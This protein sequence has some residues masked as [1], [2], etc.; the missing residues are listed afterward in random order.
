MA[1][2]KEN[3]KASGREKKRARFR[4]APSTIA[5]RKQVRPSIY[6]L[7]W[8]IF[9]ALSLLIVLLCV[10]TQQSL[11]RQTY[12]TEAT[13]WIAE[14]GR[15]LRE[16]VWQRPPEEFGDN[17]SGYLRYL[18]SEYDVELVILSEE[19]KVLFPQE[20]K[21]D[22]EYPMI[23]EYFDYS[24]ELK[25]MLEKMAKTGETESVYS[26]D[27]EYVYGAEMQ[28]FGEYKTY[29]YIA[30]SAD[31]FI[32]AISKMAVRMT[33]IAVFVIVLAFAVSSA[34]S[35]WVTRPI[36]E[37]TEKAKLLAK[38]N[39]DVD[40]YGVDYAEDMVEL[41][42][43]LNF[44]RDE[45]SKTDRMQKE[46]IA[47]VS[48]DFRTPLTMIKAYA[49]MIIEI[50]GDVP[51]KRNKHAQVIV[52]EADRLTSLVND[53]LDLSKIRSGINT[54][55]QE[56]FDMSAYTFEILDRFAYLKE[57]N[58][59]RFVTDIDEDLY[60]R[61]D[62][63]KIGQVLYNLIGNAVNYTGDDKTV[64]VSLKKENEKSF[65]FSVTDTGVGIKPE[66]LSAVWDRYYR[67]SEMHKR[68]VKGMG[69]GLSIVRT[70]L[71]KH[72]FKFGINSEVGKGSTFYVLF[73]LVGENTFEKTSPNA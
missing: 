45:L 61:A 20:Q 36:S 34:V 52:E 14:T 32:S 69:L 33:L 8:T 63:L 40:F 2:K 54:L 62:E 24:D 39:F 18:A 7:L 22:P 10:F 21:F 70:I 35:G 17:Y 19:G 48:H 3:S 67:S 47:N 5:R 43:T 27:G 38:G 60:T 58:G 29:L 57:T 68:P 51:E 53:I 13:R 6:F 72:N 56:E 15:T 41:A 64:Y 26:V 71:E 59:Y 1:K 11:M 50:S 4:R 12:E 73:P 30:R 31:L 23:R 44:A 25:V 16:R 49:S 66:E 28:G 42:E 37:M 55:K 9:T 65:R 46:L